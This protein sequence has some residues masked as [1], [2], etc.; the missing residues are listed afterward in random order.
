MPKM[1]MPF[2]RPGDT[3]GICA[4]ARWV[5]EDQLQP[6][7]DIIH[8][9]GFKTKVMPQVFFQNGQLAGTDEERIQGLLACITDPSIQAIIVARGGYGTVRVVDAIPEVVIQDNS[10]WLCGYSDITVLHNRWNNMGIPTIHSTM[11]ISFPNATPFALDQLYNALTGQWRGRSWSAPSSIKQQLEGVIVGGNLSV[12]YSQLGSRTQLNTKGKIL[13]LEDVDEMIYHLDR[14]LLGLKRAGL[15]D[16]IKGLLLGGFTQMKDNT[17]AFGFSA[18]NPWGSTVTDIFQELAHGLN[19]PIAFDFP[20]G[21]WEQNE[22][23]YLGMNVKLL[24]QVDNSLTLS[25]DFPPV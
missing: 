23:F 3:I 13:F 14:M 5:T 12:V 22:A 18:D 10:K 6:A 17:Q 16:D 25:M 15:L 9:W 11:P 19:I 8:R 1:M 2:L 4:T 24:P 20:A 7:L 21:H